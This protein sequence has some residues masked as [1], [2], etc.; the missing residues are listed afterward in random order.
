MDY[1]ST[2]TIE[3]ARPGVKI[4]VARMSF[5]RRL[6]LM[7]GVRDL[8]RQ[9][10]FLEAGPSPGDGMEAALLH[11]EIDRMLV[12]W[13]VVGVSGL[14]VDG[15]EANAEALIASGPEDVFREALAA[16]RHQ[17]GLSEE[18]RKNSSSPSTFNSP[19]GPVGS[20]T[21]AEDPAWK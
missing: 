8:A 6:E 11:A 20:A 17:A 12:T 5:G 3:S 18:E 4:R 13:G 14:L 1:E 21:R 7:R 10:E 15:A 2:L 9:I 19:T 16:V